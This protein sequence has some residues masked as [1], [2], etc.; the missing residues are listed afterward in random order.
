MNRNNKTDIHINKF[1]EQL[2]IL[3]LKKESNFGFKT[4]LEKLPNLS[5]FQF[6]KA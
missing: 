1:I 6:Y 3:T 5:Q 4:Q 2:S